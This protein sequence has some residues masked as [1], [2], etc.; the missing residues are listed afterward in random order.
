MALK[1]TAIR[2]AKPRGKLYRLRVDEGLYIEV[3]PQGK[4]LWRFRYKKPV[5]GKYSMMALGQYPAVTLKAARAER[6]KCLEL[7]SMDID[8]IDYRREQQQKK[9]LAAAN[10]FRAVAEDWKEQYLARK[11]PAHLKRTWSI[12]ERCILPYLG[13]QPIANI[14]APDILKMARFHEKRGTLETA[15]RAIQTTGQIFRHGIIIGTCLS[16]PTPALKGAIQTPAKKHMAATTDPME[17]GSYLR[18]F[19]AFKGTPVVAVAIRLLPLLFCRPGELRT[20][21]WNDIDLE[22]GEWRYTASKT[23]TDHLVPLSRQAIALLKEIQ[24]LTGHLPGGWVFIGGRSPLRP[25]SEAAVNAAYRRLGIDTKT[26]LTGHGWRAVART[27]LH[28]QLGYPP[29]VIEHQLAHAVPDTLG[30]AY[31]RTR[32][33][34][35]RQEM[36]QAWA[37]YLDKLKTGAEVVCLPVRQ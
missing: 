2:N 12:V 30:R 25:M 32:F 29:E 17:V 18:A 14:T 11:S 26:E 36:M 31:N 19:D 16:D 10:T 34:E 23:D 13:D 6:D 28:E 35:Q 20:M 4:K 15:R 8:P 33:I 24:P 5:S 3:T 27:L 21:R 7:L 9:Q 22:T 37:D 1:D